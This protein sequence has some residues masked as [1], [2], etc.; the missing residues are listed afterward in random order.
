MRKTVF[1]CLLSAIACLVSSCSSSE[2][3]KK[4]EAKMQKAIESSPVFIALKDISKALGEYRAANRRWPDS[5]AELLGWMK[6][7]GKSTERLEKQFESVD[8]TTSR[9]GKKENLKIAYILK[10]NATNGVLNLNLSLDILDDPPAEIQGKS[11]Q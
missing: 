6:N 2:S 5:Y 1:V 8:I 4:A 3:E 9:S 11:K 10:G 7:T